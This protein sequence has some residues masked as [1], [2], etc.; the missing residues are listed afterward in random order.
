MPWSRRR[1][2]AEAAGGPPPEFEPETDGA[3]PWLFLCPSLLSVA[4]LVLLP[5]LDAVRRS[6][7]SAMSGQF[8]GFK[9]YAAV[10]RKEAFRLAAANTAR[11][12]VVCIPLLPRY[13]TLRPYVELLLDSPKFFTMFWNSCR[14]V[15]PVVAGQVLISAPVAWAFA[16]LRFRGEKAL[17][18]LY[19]VLMLMPFQVTMVSS[20][21]VLDGL[22]LLDTVWA[23][24]LPGAVSTF[25]VFLMARFF[26]AIP[27]ALTEAAALDGAG[28]LRTFLHVGLPLGAPGLLSAVVLGFLE[29]W[30]ALEQPLTFLKDK[31][32]WPLSLYLPPVTADN[33]GV[34]LA[35]SVVMLLPALLIF[36]FGQKYLEQGIA[37][38]GLKD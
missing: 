9:N 24:I 28:P 21:L 5:F 11:F 32:L 35:A 18:S 22:G 23:V 1:V 37:A 8:V 19:I 16:R 27:S 34:S 38:A 15:A 6:F 30:N 14:Q 25:P 26:T 2:P 12:V 3:V 31:T 4:V 13:P 33:A 7:F 10:L 20:Y 17:F 36:L 29:Y